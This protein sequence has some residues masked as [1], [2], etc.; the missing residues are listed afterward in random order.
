LRQKFKKD[1]TYR[2]TEEYGVYAIQ[3]RIVITLSLTHMIGHLN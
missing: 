1:D 3:S 2:E